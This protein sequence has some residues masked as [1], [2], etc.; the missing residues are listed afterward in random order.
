MLFR[1]QTARIRISIHGTSIAMSQGM[2]LPYALKRS[3]DAT[4]IVVISTTLAILGANHFERSGPDR[5]LLEQLKAMHQ[6]RDAREQDGQT[7]GV[8]V[9]PDKAFPASIAERYAQR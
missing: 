5:Q 3:A 8:M 6:A 4:V 1:Q 7:S 9:C 2:S